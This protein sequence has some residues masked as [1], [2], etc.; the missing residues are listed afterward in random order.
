[1]V[2]VFPGRF[3]MKPQKAP[4]LTGR[5]TV[6]AG[7]GKSKARRAGEN[8]RGGQRGGKSAEG[9]EKREKMEDNNGQSTLR[10]ENVSRACLLKPNVLEAKKE[11]VVIGCKQ[12]IYSCKHPL[13]EFGLCFPVPMQGEECPCRRR[14]GVGGSSWNVILAL[15]AEKVR[16]KIDSEFLQ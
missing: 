2:S 8:V 4:A 16:Q 11:H 6:K 13:A 10:R 15:M 14:E 3:V 1:M 7:A 9:S 12:S 5:Q